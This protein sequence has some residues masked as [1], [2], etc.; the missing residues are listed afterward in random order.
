MK[1]RNRYKIVERHYFHKDTQYVLKEHLWWF[2]YETRHQS[3]NR[4][5]IEKLK[6]ILEH[7]N[8]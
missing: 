6:Q 5:T 3:P 8:L 2:I 4:A 1:E 7:K